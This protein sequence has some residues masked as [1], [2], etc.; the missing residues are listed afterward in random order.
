MTLGGPSL[1]GELLLLLL[2]PLPVSG[3]PLGEFLLTPSWLR[4]GQRWLAVVT[5]R[6]AAS[7]S[8]ATWIPDLFGTLCRAVIAIHIAIAF[9][10]AKSP[11]LQ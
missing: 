8:A 11:S 2:L 6:Q 9:E 3:E 10:T 5:G 7:L 4:P 1:S